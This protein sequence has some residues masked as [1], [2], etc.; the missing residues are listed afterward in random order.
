[1]GCIGDQQSAL[2]G[3]MCFKTGEAKNTFGTGCF[4]LMNVGNQAKFSDNG[5]LGTVGFKLGDKPCVYAIE[6][7]IAGAGATIEWMRNNLEFFKHPAQVEG[8]CRKVEGTEGVVFVPAFG[9][10]LAPYWQPTARGTIVGMTYKTTK[11]HIMRAALQAITM[12]VRDV[13][14]AMHQDSGIKL[15]ALKVDGGLTRNRLLMEMQADALNVDLHVPLMKETTALGAALCA[16]LAA[17]T[18]KSLDD[19]RRV[20]QSELPSEVVKPTLTD[21]SVRLERAREW[22]RAIKK[23]RWAKL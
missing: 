1:M 18:W 13:I 16:G 19:L 21:N 14:E 3:N 17:G 2:F 10:L 12:Q 7:S 8:M 11:V 15:T 22:S 20:G 6:G 9:G 5:L 4:L 23:A